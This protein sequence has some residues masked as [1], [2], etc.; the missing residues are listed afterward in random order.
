MM[1]SKTT[2]EL[3]D[4]GRQVTREVARLKA[5]ILGLVVGLV[6]GIGLF[7]MTVILLI[8]NGPD[9]G[10]HLQLLGAYFIGYDVTWTGALVGFAWAFTCGAVCGWAVGMLYNRIVGVR[11]NQ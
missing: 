7:I 6:A 10:A 11:L 9:T 5:G 2:G 8:K 4:A 1:G 3:P